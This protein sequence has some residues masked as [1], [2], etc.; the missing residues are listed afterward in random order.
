[1]N[2]I[3]GLAFIALSTVIAAITPAKQVLA[4][5]GS[6]GGTLGKTDKSSSG[7]R[8]VAPPASAKPTQQSNRPARVGRTDNT[9]TIGGKWAW[10]AKCDDGSNWT[11][12]FDLVQNSDHTVSGPAAGNDGSGSLS[13][14]LAG[15]RLTG[16]RTYMDHSNQITF[17]VAVG[18][19]SLQGSESSLSHGTCRYQ[20]NRS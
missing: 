9:P 12:T 10:T 1:M 18:G 17:T 16:K 19:H 2:R 20:A 11:G 13:M 5:A 4:Q 15:N 7:D 14:Q 3:I 6:T 8:E